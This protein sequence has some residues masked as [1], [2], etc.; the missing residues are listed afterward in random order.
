MSVIASAPGKVMIAGEYA[1]LSGAHA[2][3]LAVGARA[4]ASVWAREA[5]RSAAAANDSPGAV[6]LPPEVL[7]T[8][9]EAERALGVDPM[10]LTIDTS[11]LREGD[12][13]L[14]LGSSAAGAV[15]A[16]AAIFASGG[17][18]PAGARRRIFDAAL[19]GHRA[20]APNGSGA[21]VASAAF[22]GLVRYRRDGDEV[23]IE[24][25][26]MPRS[27]RAWLVWTGTPVRTSELVERVRA[28]AARDAASHGAAI[29]AIRSAA[30]ELER[31]MVKDDAYAIV[32]ATRAHHDAMRVLGERADAP[33]VTPALA[34][35]AEIARAHGGASKP[36]GAGGGDVA[37]AFLPSATDVASLR[38]E[39][40]RADLRLL[41]L[42]LGDDGARSE[43]ATTRGAN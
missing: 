6:T 5:D 13:K 28:L 2:L 10:Q 17:I 33:I 12:R 34:R 7:L 19:A 18:D 30:V 25:R 42:P 21:D 37:V 27:L 16:A 15:A 22:G 9:R 14:G 23:E 3:V 1:V 40:A 4:R 36:S 41:D 11:A 26:A 31:A 20:I 32:S 43:T 35:L 39:L 38:A 24:T 8:Q 29:E